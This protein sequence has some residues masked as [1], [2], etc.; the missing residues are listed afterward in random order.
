MKS[1]VETSCEEGIFRH[2]LQGGRLF[3][4]FP[5]F[6][7]GGLFSPFILV[8]YFN[9]PIVLPPSGQPLSAEVT[10]MIFQHGN[11]QSSCLPPAIREGLVKQPGSLQRLQRMKFV[12][13]GGA[14]LPKS[15]GD[16]VGSAGTKI[17]N[18]IASTESGIMQHLEVGQGEWEYMR[19]G[20]QSGIE[21]RPHSDG[22]YEIIVRKPGLEGLQAVF[23]LFPLIDEYATKDL[24]AP[25]PDPRKSDFWL[26]H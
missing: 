10:D 11:V 19:F 23:E 2:I 20:P 17:Y 25:H 1:M 4:A 8:P 9:I 21:F 24:F 5:L 26:C 12:I 18:M 15:F 22:L 13:A 14:L 16:A 3:N 7:A 6:H